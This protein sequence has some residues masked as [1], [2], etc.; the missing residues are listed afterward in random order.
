[1]LDI[2]YLINPWWENKPSKI[3]IKR[4]KY[5]ELIRECLPRNQAVLLVGS[6]R[7]GKTTLLYQSVNTLLKEKGVPPTNILYILLD[8]PKFAGVS[9]SEIVEKFRQE[10]GL[11]RSEKIYVFCDE[12][13]Y[14]KNW[15]QEVKAMYDTENIKFFLSGSAST[16]ITQKTGFLSGRFVKIKV[17]PLDFSE[18]L[19][20][21]DN[22]VGKGESYLY[23]KL[24]LDYLNTGGYP[25]YVLS[26]SPQYFADLTESIIFK[27][28]VNLY[29]IKNPAV[30]RD[31]LLLLADRSGHQASFTKMS[32]ILGISVDTVRN[33]TNYLKQSFL[34]DEI[35]RHSESR[36]KRIYSAKKFYLNDN[37]LLFHLQGRL[38]RGAAAERTLFKF[39]ERHH[40]TVS[41]YYENG[42][43]VDFVVKDGNSQFLLESKFTDDF[44]N[45]KVLGNLKKA[46]KDLDI[47]KA[48]LAT[49]DKAD[50]VREEKLTISLV[51]AWKFVLEKN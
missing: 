12:V 21:R 47:D 40:K 18:F 41:F 14:G 4:E 20:F 42:F 24:F 22:T 10:H 44:D 50:V 45:K 48:V 19:L 51:P 35:P 39:L 5:L 1:M 28:I 13:Q 6:R 25:E 16:L 30:V 46:A 2:L 9:I 26:P 8:H 34:V 29:G 23:K 31:L 38:N 36:S 37:G 33:Y 43:E 3:G 15:E 17:E 11:P 27:D 7:V 32:K 49:E